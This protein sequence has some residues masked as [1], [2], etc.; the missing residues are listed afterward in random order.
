[1]GRTTQVTT[2]AVPE[3][4]PEGH[5]NPRVPVSPP[6][7]VTSCFG[8]GA[9]GSVSPHRTGMRLSGPSNLRAE[10]GKPQENLRNSFEEPE[11]EF[12]HSH[13]I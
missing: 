8:E 5:H 6:P 2:K 1:M 13:V 11:P 10:R 4:S 7:Q 9:Q 3:R 12:T